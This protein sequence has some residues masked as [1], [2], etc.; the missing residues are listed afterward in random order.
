MK[1]RRLSISQR[2]AF[3]GIIFLLPFFI[4]FA[5]FQIYPFFS[6][7][8]TSFTN[9]NL[10]SLTQKFVGFK[11]YVSV[12]QDKLFITS[13]KNTFIYLLIDGIGV[14]VFGM[15][16]AIALNK[17]I[18]GLSF[19]RTTYY[20]PVLVDWTIVSIVFLFIL[21]PNFGIANYFLR[22]M[23]LP[24]QKFLTSPKQALI[25]IAIAS[26]WKGVGYYAVLFLAALQDVPEVLKEAASLDGAGPV[27]IFFHISLPHMM[28]VVV[29]VVLMAFIGSL[30]GFDQFYIMT[31]GGPARS[32]T[33][34]MYYFYEVA[35]TNM[36]TSKGATIAILFTIIVLA[37]TGTQ[38]LLSNKLA[39]VEGV[40]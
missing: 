27:R 36:N 13:L 17:K 7:L 12:L 20:I 21:E 5:I 30:K 25:I 33:T 28:P 35:F 6:T 10:M 34:I 15:L 11:N 29:F 19:F 3:I 4:H 32:T 9:A 38:R 31:S 26:V 8:V 2:K 16:M 1:N 23:G 14:V 39:G 22:E 24:T 40:N 18:R 37:F